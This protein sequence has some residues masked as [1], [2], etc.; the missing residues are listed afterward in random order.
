MQYY[1]AKPI[2]TT[3]RKAGD[4]ARNGIPFENSNGQLYGTWDTPDTY[5]VYSY[6]T[7]WP[8]FVYDNTSST[9]YE[10]E[11]KYSVTTSRHHSQAH[12]LTETTKLSRNALRNLIDLLRVK[13]RMGLAA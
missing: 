3:C 13:R 1:N 6:G 5:V 9:W 4:Y 7:H 10:N 8:L 11:D 12:P 2:R